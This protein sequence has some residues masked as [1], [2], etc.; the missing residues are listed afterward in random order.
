MDLMDAET[1]H[2]LLLRKLSW[3][4]KVG[5]IPNFEKSCLFPELTQSFFGTQFHTPVGLAAGYD[6]Y[7]VAVPAFEKIGFGFVEL[8]SVTP[9]PQ[10]GNPRPRMYRLPLDEAMVNRMGLNNPG[11]DV[12]FPRVRLAQS[13]LSRMPVMVNLAK[14]NAS[15]DPADDY[16]AGVQR[17]EGIADC[18][19]L[20]LSCPNVTGFKNL[21]DPEMAGNILK[22]IARIRQ[23][24]ALKTPV[25]VKIGP[26]LTDAHLKA[27]VTL[28]LESGIDGIV[29]TNLTHERPDS[30]KTARSL[31]PEQ[32]G[33]SGPPMEELATN[34][35]RK[36]YELSKG[37]L[38]IIGVGG[39][40]SAASAYAK[41]R[42]GASLV[43]LYT[44]LVYKGFR[45]IPEI[46]QGL[47]TLLKKDGFSHI[48]QAVGADHISDNSAGHSADH[49]SEH[50]AG[51]SQEFT[52]SSI[53]QQR[54]FS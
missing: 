20:N 44:A 21:Q 30:M 5:L 25:F 6:K 29:A 18:V 22:R 1:R 46:A 49:S 36:I 3:R 7:A 11:Y 23:Q 9:L 17:C 33:L 26:D 8:G 41:I 2:K 47:V 48:S 54:S 38:V 52:S 31:Q 51:H 43:E 39:I 50:T 28:C 40:H 32:G 45:L 27:L 19:V 16:E 37:D 13:R 15:T 10:Q 14:G 34:T 12:F 4:L 24:K 42:A 35:I 53:P